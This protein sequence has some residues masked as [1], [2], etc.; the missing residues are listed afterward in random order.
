V[1][2]DESFLDKFRINHKDFETLMEDWF[3]DEEWPVKKGERY[4]P[5]QYL[6]DPYIM[7]NVMIYRLYDEETS[8][9]F[10]M[11]WF[12]MAYT[13]AK[14]RKDSTGPTSYPSVS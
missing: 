8:T 9:H 12:L 5:A 7:L 10:R 2:L 13:V 4:I 1:S 11:E 3:V 14:T 6:K